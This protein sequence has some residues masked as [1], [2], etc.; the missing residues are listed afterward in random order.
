MSSIFWR[1]QERRLW[2]YPLRLSHTHLHRIYPEHIYRIPQSIVLRL[3]DH[4]LC[5]SWYYW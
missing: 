1:F 2:L 5:L 3:G 4:E